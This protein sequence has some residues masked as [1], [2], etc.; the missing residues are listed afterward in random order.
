MFL[1]HHGADYATV[2]LDIADSAVQGIGRLGRCAIPPLRNCDLVPSVLQ[3][4]LRQFA[5][6]LAQLPQ[7][8]E[9]AAVSHPY[10]D[11]PNTACCLGQFLYI[12]H[13]VAFPK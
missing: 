13:I 12:F 8:F 9:V 1:P 5:V 2:L 4:D 11:I 10:Q 3:A 6:E 7:H